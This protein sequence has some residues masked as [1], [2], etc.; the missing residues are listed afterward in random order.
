MWGTLENMAQI[1]V[2][3]TTCMVAFSAWDFLRDQSPEYAHAESPGVLYYSGIA[4]NEAV[5]LTS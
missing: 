1:L 4:I 2:S 5:D 3:L